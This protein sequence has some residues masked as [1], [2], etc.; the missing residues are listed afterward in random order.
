ML[1]KSGFTG[2][3]KSAVHTMGE[4]DSTEEHMGMTV[5]NTML[6]GILGQPLS[7]ADVPTPYKIDNNLCVKWNFVSAFQPFSRQ[8]DTTRYFCGPGNQENVRH[9]FATKLNLNR[10][11]QGAFSKLHEV[12]GTFYRPMFFEFPEDPLMY[13]DVQ[14]NVMLGSALKLSLNSY[15]TS[16]VSTNFTFPAGLWCQVFNEHGQ[17]V[18][19]C[20]KS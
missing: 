6:Y 3:G 1:S 2:V 17:G 9:A 11:Y 16:S 10:Y 19:E 8:L 5:V 13:E 15:N 18:N 20:F 14:N 4:I 7:G 12:G